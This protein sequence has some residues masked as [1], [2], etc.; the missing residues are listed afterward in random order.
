ML[1]LFS[2]IAR[3]FPRE[4][5][6]H[7]AARLGEGEGG[8]TRALEGVLPMMMAGMARQAETSDAQLLFEWSS[9]AYQTGMLGVLGSGTA[10]GGAMMHGETLLLVLFGNSWESIANSVSRYAHVKRTTASTLLT[11]VS[12][13]LPGLLGQYAEHNRLSATAAAANLIG[14]KSQLNGLIP[15]GMRTVADALG[16]TAETPP[17]K[18]QNWE[19]RL[20][21]WVLMLAAALSLPSTHSGIGSRELPPAAAKLVPGQL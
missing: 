10:A 11:L 20:I 4:L 9:R 3:A 15:V 13:V 5:I 1:D 2:A 6:R 18:V 17:S 8:M 14:I 7:L 21:S 16:L 12:A 19:G